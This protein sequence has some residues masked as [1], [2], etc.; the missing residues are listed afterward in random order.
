MIIYHPAY[1]INHCIFRFVCLLSDT[2]QNQLDWKTLQILD[3]YYVFPH[4]LAEIRMP[5]NPVV[6]K[7]ALRS[8]PK[9][10][11]SLPNPKRLMFGLKA[12]HNETARALVAKGMFDKGLYLKNIIKLDIDKIPESLA[13][14][15]GKN[16]KRNT[17]WYKLLTHVFTTYPLKGKNGLKSRTQL[18]ESRYDAD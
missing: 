6:T 2:E 17:N 8:I 14:Q 9:P 1:D 16:E 7:Q 11:E 5:Y 12:L 18:M 13:C 10:Y 15:I 3:F 4:L